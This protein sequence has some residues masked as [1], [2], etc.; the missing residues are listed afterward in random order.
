MT[1][2][3]RTL[4]G[5]ILAGIIS[6]CIVFL[7]MSCAQPAPSKGASPCQVTKQ[8]N[9][10]VILCPGQEPVSILNGSDGAKGDTGEVG[11]TGPQGAPGEAATSVT[12]VQ[13]CPG[14]PSY[15]HWYES[16]VCIDGSL[17][18]VFWQNGAPFFSLLPAGVYR[19][20]DGAGCTFTVAVGCEVTR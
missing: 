3:T 1:L 6:F 5:S 19:S 15:G 17:Y 14:A 8:D 9:G 4:I 18:A 10:A 20:T 12:A 7:C 16:G 2:K 13:F 11:A